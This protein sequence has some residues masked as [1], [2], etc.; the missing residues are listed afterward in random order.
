MTDLFAISK[1]DCTVVVVFFKYEQHKHLFYDA[2]A[3]TN[4]S[5]YNS[6]CFDVLF[7]HCSIYSTKNGSLERNSGFILNNK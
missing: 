4:S 1:F 2:C 7:T 3:Q 6:I 5:S